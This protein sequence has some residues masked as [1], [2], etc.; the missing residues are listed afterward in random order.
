MPSAS[1][2]SNQQSDGITNLQSI[3]GMPSQ[4]GFGSAVFWELVER[5]ADLES[6]ALKYYRYFVGEHWEQFGEDA[7]MSCWQQVY[8]RQAG[9][10][11]D[12]VGE[13]RSITN[14][15]AK[16]SVPMIL[17]EIS[18]AEAARKALS[19]V[20]DDAEMG[21]LAVY[22]LGDGAAMSGLLIAGRENSG[23][24]IFLVFLLD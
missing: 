24:A 22:T 1:D 20:Y 4:A 5:A 18:D 6:V 15:E 2:L 8:V 12:I 14:P 13:L 10:S 21:N 19:E 17:D 16:L 9:A 7:W 11:P 3:Y 23:R